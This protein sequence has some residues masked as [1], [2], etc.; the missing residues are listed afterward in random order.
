MLAK[1]SD[2]LGGR[3]RPIAAARHDRLSSDAEPGRRRDARQVPLFLAAAR[4]ALRPRWHM[5][6]GNRRS[7]QVEADDMVEQ[8]GAKAAGDGLGDLDRRESD[9]TPRQ[10]V[11]AER[12]GGNALRLLPVEESFDLTIPLHAVGEAHPARAL[13]RTENRA[14]QKDESGGLY[15]Q[16]FLLLCQP[17][18]VEFRK[19][20]VE[21]VVHRHNGQIS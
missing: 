10:H 11:L 13:S 1:A 21:I 18:A 17:L 12:R 4:R 9:R 7:D 8:I 5:M 19:L 14:D 6:P 15:Q 20:I 3:H 2:R 16:P